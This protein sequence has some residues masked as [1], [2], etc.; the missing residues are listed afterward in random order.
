MEETVCERVDRLIKKRETSRR[1]IAI[2]AGISPSTLQSALQRNRGLSLDLLFPLSE[3]LGVTVQYLETGIEPPEIPPPT[4]EDQA[5]FADKEGIDSFLAEMFRLS[6]KLNKT[7]KR[8]AI[9]RVKELCEIPRY[10]VSN[11]TWQEANTDG[12]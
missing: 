6:L 3:A 1:K 10:R 9:E 2:T 11:P 7:G 4:D 5:D 12:E 8:V